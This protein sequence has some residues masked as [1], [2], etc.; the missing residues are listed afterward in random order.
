MT[1]GLTADDERWNG[2]NPGHP[3]SR[4]RRMFRRQLTLALALLALAVVLEGAFAF[5][6]LRDAARLAER[7]AATGDILAGFVELSAHKQAVRTWVS[8]RQ[9]EG[10]AGPEERERLHAALRDTLGRLEEDARRPLRLD[11]AAT[12]ADLHLARR[13]ALADLADAFGE[14]ERRLATVEPLDASADARAARDALARVFEVADGRSMR[15]LIA[16]NIARERTV[17]AR[18][19]A[20]AATALDHVGRLWLWTAAALA[21]VALVL[22]G[23]FTRALRRPLDGLVAGAEALQQGDLGHRIEPVGAHEFVAVAQSFNRMASELARHRDDEAQA[24]QRLGEQ[25]RARTAEL[26]AALES[27]KQADT[28]RRQLFA[29]V[30]HELRTPTTAIRGEAEV[31]LRGRDRPPEEYRAALNRILE[32]SR[33]LALV[34]DDLLTMARTDIDALAL[35]RGPVDLRLS[36]AEALVQARALAESRG[37][38]LRCEEP[39]GPVVLLGD[40]QRLRQLLALLLDNAV[41]SSRPGGRV[42]VRVEFDARPDE[43]PSCTVVVRDEGIGIAPEELPHVFERNFRGDRAR[44]HRADGSGL[45]LSIGIALARA[46]GGE[47]GLESPPGD[48]TT[49]RLRLPLAALEHPEASLA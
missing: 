45:G 32:T 43:P 7:A 19:R 20:A 16:A 5:W 10:S 3:A 2:Q 23:V 15:D 39:R 38:E 48:G 22:A 28:R 33:Q 8:Q 27:L 21:L 35:N 34:I 17:L 41:R 30:S 1:S 9:L 40:A 6:S 31:T 37:V 47:I 42:D 12:T 36:L 13:D 46:N 44:R 14:L 29:D 25:V 4:R 49:A 24:R 26:Q 18:E 11:R